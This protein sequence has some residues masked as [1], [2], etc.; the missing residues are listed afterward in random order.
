MARHKTFP[1]RR[2]ALVATLGVATMLGGCAD[3][4]KFPSLARRPAEDIYRTARATPPAPPPAVM[5][6]GMARRLADLTAQARKAHSAFESA[7]PAA[8]RAVSAARG[9]AKGTENWSVASLAVARLES[10]RAQAGLPL[11]DLDRLEAEASNR[12]VDGS[13]AD[14]KAVLTA[15]SEVEALVA[16]ETSVIDSL[17]SQLA[18]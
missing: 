16:G 18:G 9:A 10:A 17:L 8:T 3:R 12:A 6:E 5:S 11:A 4:A 7:R 14:L 13:D 1:A 2:T 15:R